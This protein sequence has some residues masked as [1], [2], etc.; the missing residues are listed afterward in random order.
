LLNTKVVLFVPCILKTKATL[1]Q[2]EKCHELISDYLGKVHK[3]AEKKDEIHVPLQ[4]VFDGAVKRKEA[5]ALLWD[6][7]HPTV[8]GHYLLAE[9]WL[10]VVGRS[11]CLNS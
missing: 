7:I 1:L 3:L 10:E 8:A 6:G 4:D 9:R 11:G 5:E 2:I